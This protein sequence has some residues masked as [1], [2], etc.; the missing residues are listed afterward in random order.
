MATTDF[1]LE[2][3]GVE[4][5]SMHAKFKNMISVTS[6]NWGLHN[7]ADPGNGD[8]GGTGAVSFQ[9]LNFSTSASK[10]SPLLAD[11]CASGKH[12]DKAVLHVCKQ[13]GAQEEYYSISLAGIV[14]VTNLS[15]H[16]GGAEVSESFTLA[17]QKIKY[18]HKPQDSKGGL[19]GAKTFTWNLPA[20]KK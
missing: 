14:M 5:E 18:D 12:F 19:G 17:F 11:A 6:F 1:N 7:T 9:Q 15:H 13:G 20:K 8:G 10:A 2:L 3:P 4:G 16:A